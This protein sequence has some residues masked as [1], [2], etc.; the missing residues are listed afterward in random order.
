M[1]CVCST[2]RRCRCRSTSTNRPTT[3][4]SAVIHPQP[5]TTTTT[6]T[7]IETD[8]NSVTPSRTASVPASVASTSSPARD[9]TSLAAGGIQFYQRAL[10]QRGL[11]ASVRI[12]SS[13]IGLGGSNAASDV[14]EVISVVPRSPVQRRRCRCVD[15][16]QPHEHGRFDQPSSATSCDLIC[17]CGNADRPNRTSISTLSDT[18]S[19]RRQPIMVPP[20]VCVGSGSPVKFQTMQPPTSHRGCNQKAMIV[21]TRPVSGSGAEFCPECRTVELV[22][23]LDSAGN[24]RG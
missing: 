22:Q 14:P 5:S 10:L 2:E 23:Y 21:V 12:R 9:A 24:D 6:T 7:T 17:D 19:P 16:Q 3:S 13:G 1:M 20:P 4:C 8:S 18:T 11:Y 15:P